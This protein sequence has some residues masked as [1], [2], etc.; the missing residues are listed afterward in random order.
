M[1]PFQMAPCP[2]ENLGR[3]LACKCCC[4]AIDQSG[5]LMM[6]QPSSCGRQLNYMVVKYITMSLASHWFI[7]SQVIVSSR[8]SNYASIYV[9]IRFNIVFVAFS[10]ELVDSDICPTTHLWWYFILPHYIIHVLTNCWT[11]VQTWLDKN[12]NILFV[13]FK[14][15]IKNF[16]TRSSSWTFKGK[17]SHISGKYTERVLTG[18]FKA[19][20]IDFLHDILYLSIHLLDKSHNCDP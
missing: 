11:S 5:C 18:I 19:F 10:D 2:F 6:V 17:H 9:I 7:V 12:R 3:T 14:P 1:C 8:I 20:L 13:L 4:C 16:I 15:F